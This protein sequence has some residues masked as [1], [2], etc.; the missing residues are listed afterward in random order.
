[1]NQ[2]PIGCTGQECPDDVRVGDVRQLSVLLREAAYELSESLVRLLLIVP[3]IPGVVGVH[4]G[5]LEVPY[6]DSQQIL[7]VV[8]LEGGKIL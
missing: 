8:D 3:E 5:P 2:L 1:M 4:V 7:P 6:E